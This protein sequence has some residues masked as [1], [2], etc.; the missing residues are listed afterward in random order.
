MIYYSSFTLTNRY[1][2]FKV[3]LFVNNHQ[4]FCTTPWSVFVTTLQR[5]IKQYCLPSMNASRKYTYI[6]FRPKIYKKY[7]FIARGKCWLLFEIFD[8]SVFHAMILNKVRLWPKPCQWTDNQ[9]CFLI[10]VIHSETFFS[11]NRWMYV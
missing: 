4:T 6:I 3:V 1:F 11:R 2:H 7:M 8:F 9:T 10:N 5:Y